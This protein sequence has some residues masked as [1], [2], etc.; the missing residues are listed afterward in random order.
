MFFVAACTPSLG[1]G[2]KSENPQLTGKAVAGS[3]APRTWRSLS[4]SEST[5]LENP[6]WPH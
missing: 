5:V 4:A 1:N 6:A 2:P 3:G